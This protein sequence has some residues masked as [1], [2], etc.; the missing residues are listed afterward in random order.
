MVLLGSRTVHCALP[1]VCQANLFQP[2]QQLL[3]MK[4]ERQRE[5][6][7]AFEKPCHKPQG[8]Y[9]CTNAVHSLSCSRLGRHLAVRHAFPLDENS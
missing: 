1:L 8:T 7:R 9:V 2:T 3:D 6:E 5:M 4:K